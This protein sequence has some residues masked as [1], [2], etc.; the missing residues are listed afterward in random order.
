MNTRKIGIVC[1]IGSAI[2]FGIT[3]LIA[4]MAY[5]SGSNAETL[6]FYRNVFAVPMLFAVCLKMRIPVKIKISE[7]KSMITIGIF[8]IA[9][10]TLTLYLSYNYISIGTATTLHFLYPAFVALLCWMVY[11]EQLSIAKTISLTIAMLGIVFFVDG[12]NT[13]GMVGMLLS[14]VSGLT[15]GYYMVAVEKK[16]LKQI[17]PFVLSMYF[18]MVVSVTM[19]AYNVLFSKMIWNLPAEAYVYMF[20]VS[21]GTSFIGVVLLQIGIAKLGATE[22][23]IFCLFEPI[24]SL[25]AGSIFLNEQLTLPKI[26]GSIVVLCAVGS[27]AVLDGNKSK[28]IAV[29]KN[30]G[31]HH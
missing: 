6:V 17:N 8:G 22:A 23:A 13:D 25:I 11:H 24:S 7:A 26:I 5:A 12:L 27:L 15:Y 4:K 18:A 29:I 28:K 19:F 14:L 10:T 9:A 30:R 2:L 16:G 21:L 31:F 1:T 3:P 20:L